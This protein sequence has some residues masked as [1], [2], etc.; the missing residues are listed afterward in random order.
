ME[1]DQLGPGGQVTSSYLLSF[2]AQV[3]NQVGTGA[4]AF[5][6]QTLVVKGGA[7]KGE[8]DWNSQ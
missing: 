3:T 5:A 1:I 2:A 7:A 4:A 6:Y 8:D